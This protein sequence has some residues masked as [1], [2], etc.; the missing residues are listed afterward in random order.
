MKWRMP[1]HETSLCPPC[2]ATILLRQEEA[3][4]L[5]STA[6][7]LVTILAA[8]TPPP[9]STAMTAASNTTAPVPARYEAAPVVTPVDFNEP[10][11]LRDKICGNQFDRSDSYD[12]VTK[13]SNAFC[14]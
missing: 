10:P 13:A 8:C 12:T 14:R 6:Y 9:T 4:M 3:A 7:V 11:D 2:C 1:H 5:R